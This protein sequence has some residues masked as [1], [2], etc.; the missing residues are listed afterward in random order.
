[1]VIVNPDNGIDNFGLTLNA[2]FADYEDGSERHFFFISK[3]YVSSVDTLPSGLNLVTDA[4][5]ILDFAGLN[6]NYIV[7]E[8][9]SSHLIVNS[10]V[11]DFT[12]NAHLYADKLPK[13]DGDVSVDIKAAAIEHSGLLTPV[14][15]AEIPPHGLADHGQ[16]ADRSNNVSLAD[17]GLDVSFARLNN[18]FELLEANAYEGDAPDQHEGN[19]G[20]CMALP[21]TSSLTMPAKYS[22]P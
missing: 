18:K 9:D 11:A 7:L 8:V 21:Y 2:T 14:N 5:T 19:Y 10:G 16:D 20:K 4:K 13:V 15:G 17:M 3:D 1:M 6:D 22:T 12:L